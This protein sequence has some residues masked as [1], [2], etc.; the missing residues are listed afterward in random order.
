MTRGSLLSPSPSLTSVLR[1]NSI[2]ARVT[3]ASDAF[4]ASLRANVNAAGSQFD[5]LSRGGRRYRQQRC[6]LEG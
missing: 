6:Q 5:V 4:D 2:L 3:F 1:H